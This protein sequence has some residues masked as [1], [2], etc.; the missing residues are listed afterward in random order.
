MRNCLMGDMFVQ[1]KL[2]SSAA[3]DKVCLTIADLHRFNICGF[4]VALLWILF[5]VHA[6][7]T[8]P[9]NTRK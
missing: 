1:R 3:A 9:A 5:I 2:A 8:T 7:Y 4:F 6:N